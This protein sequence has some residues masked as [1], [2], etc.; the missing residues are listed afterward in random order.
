MRL[1]LASTI[2]SSL[3]AGFAIAQTPRYTVTDLG[4]LGPLGQ[5]Y[6]ITNNGLISGT[7]AVAGGA[8]QAALWYAGLKGNIGTPGL[9][10]QNS[11]A[12]GANERGQA[13][14]LAQTS[15]PDPNGE[16]FC[17]LKALG[18][19]SAGT[20]CLPSLWQYGVMVPLPTLGGS[21]GTAYQVN[22]RGDIA[23]F[24]ENTTLDPNCPAPQKF[25]FEPAIWQQGQIQQLPTI[26]GDPDGVAE[27]INDNGQVAGASGTCS[28]FNVNT[29]VGLQ[30]NHAL[31][32]E[33]GTVI[34]LGNLGGTVK[35]FGNLAFNINNQGQVV[36][37]SGVRGDA[38]FHGFLWTKATGM[39]DLGTLQGDA[40]STAIGINDSGD[41][42]GVSLSANFNPRAYLRQNGIMTDLNTLIPANSP[43]SLL[44]ACSINAS[45]QIV[46]V[47]VTSAGE[48]HG[49]LATPINSGTGA[50]NGTNAVVAP[51]SLTTTQP[52]V[53]LDA[54][55][56][57]SASGNLHYLFQ[58]VPG[59]KLPALLQSPSDPK[60]TVDFVSGPGL[61]LVQLTVTDV[62]GATAKSPVIMLNYQP[63]P[64]ASSK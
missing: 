27:A 51:L 35:G 54:S 60:A 18:L 46:G 64:T 11:I 14:G 43:L 58:V 39:Q 56:S 34:D 32:W 2:A 36:G 63:S 50:N 12:F 57:T 45:G 59:S 41:V 7:A 33:T 26:A 25:Q 40:N 17:G 44:V 53:V 31:L 4:A 9:G 1:I 29:L 10:G 8:E 30:P 38:N 16:D 37:V 49:Y 13:V 24:A 19:P 47:A 28:T 52:S 48:V 5:P 20:T 62:S 6:F 15:T 61:Y 23:G 3:L 42:V 55:G 22:H 21:N